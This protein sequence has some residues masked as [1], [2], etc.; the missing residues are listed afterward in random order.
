LHGVIISGWL[1]SVIFKE[2]IHFASKFAEGVLDLLNMSALWSFFFCA[3]WPLKRQLSLAD[4]LHIDDIFSLKNEK[5]IGR[6]NISFDRLKFS[7]AVRPRGHNNN[8]NNSQPFYF[9]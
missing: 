7:L 2:I 3:L 9:A 5:K 1:G 4:I 6:T 8:N